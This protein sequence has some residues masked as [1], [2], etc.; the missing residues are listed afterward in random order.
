MEKSIL[1]LLLILSLVGGIQ[2][3]YAEPMITVDVNGVDFQVSW[4]MDRQPEFVE[5]DA[6]YMVLDDNN[7]ILEDWQPLEKECP[8]AQGQC[9]PLDFDDDGTVI[10]GGYLHTHQHEGV[11]EHCFEVT[12]IFDGLED[13]ISSTCTFSK[14]PETITV[15]NNPVVTDEENKYNIYLSTVTL[16]AKIPPRSVNAFVGDEILQEQSV[17]NTGTVP[18]TD[19]KI[20]TEIM[21]PDDFRIDDNCNPIVHLCNACTIHHNIVT[22]E[23]GEF[24]ANGITKQAR[25]FTVAEEVG[26]V[27]HFAKVCANADGQQICADQKSILTVN[28]PEST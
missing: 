23:M 13:Q 19:V 21:N 6:R 17:I 5:F 9:G 1:G 27:Y 28:E 16:N 24:S 26:K 4:M 11:F 20:M 22:C 18:L 14:T 7:N 3:I 25:W 15:S 8:I 2:S 12:V 10:S